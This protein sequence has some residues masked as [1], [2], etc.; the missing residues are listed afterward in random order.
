[1]TRAPRV[2]FSFR[3]PYSWM[4]VHRLRRA[5]PDPH[6]V[7]RFVPFWDPDPQT[8]AA[9]RE[10]GGEFHYVQMSKAKHLYILHD[11][12]RQAA[13]LGLTM[14][15][16]I[17]V[18]P[19]WELPHLAFL[20][21]QRRGAEAAFYAEASAARWVRG[22]DI[23]QPDVIAKVAERA[24]LPG[25]ELA[26]AAHDPQARSAGVDCLMQAYEDDIFGIPYFR[27]GR[28][29]FWGLDRV[30]EFL[31]VLAAEPAGAGHRSLSLNNGG[32]AVTRGASGGYDTDTAGGCG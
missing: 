30:E 15:W 24:G 31:A 23:C 8:E 1:M 10:R 9:L 18:D 7:L 6:R 28:H 32:E 19:W 27:V 3:S 29:R 25:E 22:E 11:T 5:L 26:G 2:Y 21:A 16:P 17:D 13:Q 14:R 20:V 12:K 4:S